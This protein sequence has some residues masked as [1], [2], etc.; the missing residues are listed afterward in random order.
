[1]AFRA[2][3]SQQKRNKERARH[4]KQQQK[5]ERRLQAKA[6]RASPRTEPLGEDPD[7][8]GILPGPQPP[9]DE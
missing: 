3:P 2:R 7:I 8:A 5:A 6:R 9:R 1:V 4:E